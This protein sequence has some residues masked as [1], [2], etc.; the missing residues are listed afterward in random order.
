VDNEAKTIL[1]N[2]DSSNNMINISEILSYK[3]NHIERALENFTNKDYQA[4]II[5]SISKNIDYV[6]K[7]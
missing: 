5:F 6:L 4:E 7:S 1:S 2:E 3:I